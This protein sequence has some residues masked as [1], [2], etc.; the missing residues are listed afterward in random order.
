MLSL[1]ALWLVLP[2]QAL[3]GASD[4]G[5]ALPTLEVKLDL[6]QRTAQPTFYHR[7]QLRIVDRGR[8]VY[9]GGGMWSEQE[10][11]DFLELKTLSRKSVRVPLASFVERF[12]GVLRRYHP[13]R[14]HHH[15]SIEQLLYYDP[16]NGQAGLEI[17]DTARRQGARRHFFAFWDLRRQLISGATLVARTFA[18]TG[19]AHLI[20]IS[21]SAKRRLFYYVRDVGE[22]GR[23][24]TRQVT[25]VAFSR[26]SPRVVAQFSSAE[27]LQR[28]AY[29]DANGERALLVE[30][31]EL[32]QGRQPV[33][34]LIELSSGRVQRLP[35]PVVTYGA[36][37]SADG[38]S[39]YC[40]SAQTG[41]IWQL[42]LSSGRVLRRMQLGKRG[43]ELGFVGQRL[44]L[45][46]NVGLQF[47]DEQTLKPT[48]FVPSKVLYRGFSHVEG[49]RLLPGG[50]A[51]L[52]NGD[53]LY[54]VRF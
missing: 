7:T 39:L 13:S 18:P 6:A 19:Y 10:R 53:D 43:H 49:S 1:I 31:V 23:H 14:L 36:L 46:R 30:Y 37:F 27:R 24:R 41:E 47:I 3:S 48:S 9:L 54:V 12:G 20:P 28:R 8:M 25:I 38:R 4:G 50:R 17:A 40:Y 52:K 26:G 22:V 29:L 51:L 2:A 33:G 44:L 21:Y 15:L 5:N 35:I 11:L 32:G 45:M 16:E 42:E 34:Y